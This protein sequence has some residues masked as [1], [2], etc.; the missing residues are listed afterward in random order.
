MF[1][2]HRRSEEPSTTSKEC[3][4]KGS[5]LSRVGRQD[6]YMSL[7]DMAGKPRSSLNTRNENLVETF[8]NT[9]G[10]QDGGIF[11]LYFESPLNQFDL[12][13]LIL[14]YKAS[15]NTFNSKHFLEF[16][17]KDFMILDLKIVEKATIG[18]SVCGEWYKMRFGRI[19]A[20]ILYE[21]AKCK[22]QGG[23]LVEKIMGASKPVETEEI[24][25]GKRLESEVLKCVENLRKIKIKNSGIIMHKDYPIFG[26]SPDGVSSE[27]VIEIK[28]PSRAKT[29]E[30][31]VKNNLINRKF[32]FQLQ[33][34]MFFLNKEKGLFCVASPTFEQD[35]KVSI[36]EISLN[37]DEIK[38]IIELAISFWESNIF[39]ELIKLQ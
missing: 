17:K 16:I 22:T 29:V 24:L 23:Y 6:A 20:S 19:T 26:A 13:H 18:Q 7:K 9:A 21:A 30:N 39:T 4:W 35:N 33:L 28:C 36:Y 37:R 32:Y 12:F 15:V 38:D 25:R 31:Y 27:Y 14:K 5:A 34:N 11:D 1:W 8:L 10:R 3:Y 2:L